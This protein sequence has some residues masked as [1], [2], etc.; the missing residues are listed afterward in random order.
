M[1]P[2]THGSMGITRCDVKGAGNMERVE[3][4]K[5]VA[6]LLE[7]LHRAKHAYNRTRIQK[8]VFLGKTEGKL[9]Y[10]FEFADYLH[11][12]FS[13]SLAKAVSSL[14]A[15]G[16]LQEMRTPYEH[17]VVEYNYLLTP[18]GQGLRETCVPILT[19]DE[20][21][22]IRELGEKFDEMKLD[23]LISYVYNYVRK[24]FFRLA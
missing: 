24:T 10:T 8:M 5:D 6:L 20:K 21:K 7:M 17:N 18:S 3:K 9:P 12:P 22:K 19:E 23:E 1:D 11:G 16:M 13:V 14:V 4:K 2:Q 15:N